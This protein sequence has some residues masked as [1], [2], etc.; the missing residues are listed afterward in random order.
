MKIP[1]VPCAC[2]NHVSLRVI[3]VR[4]QC[5]EGLVGDLH[6]NMDNKL[7]DECGSCNEPLGTS[8]YIVADK[9]NCLYE[10]DPLSAVRVIPPY[11]TDVPVVR[12]R[13]SWVLIRYCGVEAWAPRANLSRTLEPRRPALEVG[14][15]PQP[16]STFRSPQTPDEQWAS[17]VEYGPRGGRYVRT[18]SGFRRYF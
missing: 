2:R 16:N 7:P 5:S 11:G 15:V 14:V 10:P 18:A 17:H 3:L 4:R 8:A 6:V 1:L 9:A 13:G 12:E